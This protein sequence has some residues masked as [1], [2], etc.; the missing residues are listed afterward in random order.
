MERILI[1]AQSEIVIGRGLA[2][3]RD[4]LPPRN[5]RRRLAILTQPG[6]ASIARGFG[7]MLTELEVAVRVLP[8]R[9][10]AKTLEVAADTYR[11]LAEVGVNRYDTVVGIGGGAVTD[12]AGFVAATYLRGVE[13]VNLPTTLLGAVD[14]AVGGK[15][16]VNLDGKNLVGA[17][18]HPT[19]VVIDLDVLESLP[20]ELLREGHAEALKAGLIGDPVLFELYEQQGP[21]APLKSVVPRAVRVKARIVQADFRETGERAFLNFGH[22]IGHAVEV[23]AG[24]SHGDAVA[25][26][27]VAAGRV[28]ELVTGFSDAP[29]MGRTI[30]ALG[31]PVAVEGVL[32]SGLMPLLGKDKKRD[33]GGLRMVL[34]RSVGRPE[35]RSVGPEAVDAGL[36][37]VGIHSTTPKGGRR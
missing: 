20:D 12:L 14:A 4:S 17:Y 23:A 34:L 24:V 5:D 30:H 21:D 7:E 2:A 35:L 25:I 15:S 33:G 29:R 13:L 10:A 28:S 3:L 8:D 19:R 11:W 22:T 18:W 36:E 9:E 16:G 27:M 32:R 31:L 37:A 6:A 26:G 1:G